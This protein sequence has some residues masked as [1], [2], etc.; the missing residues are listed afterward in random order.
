MYLDF[1]LNLKILNDFG[2]AKFFRSYVCLHI[3]TQCMHAN[4]NIKAHMFIYRCINVGK[5]APMALE[6]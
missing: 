6:E 2:K 5:C 1:M 3:Y 4:E